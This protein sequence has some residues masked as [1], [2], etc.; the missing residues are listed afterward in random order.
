MG[1]L[2]LTYE[3]EF[4]FSLA[5]DQEKPLARGKKRL[6]TYKYKYNG[7]ELQEEL[8]LNVYDYGARFYDPA[9]PRFWQLD[10]MAETSRRFSPYSYAMDNPVFFID[11]DGMYAD[12]GDFINEKGKNIGNDGKSDGKLYAIKT[13][14]TKFDSGVKSSGITNSERKD[15]EKFITE[16]SGNTAA[17]E[18]NNIAYKNSV[19]YN[20]N[21]SAREGMIAE[22]GKDDGRGGTSDENNREHGGRIK[23]SDSSIVVSDPG[24]ICNP[25]T[26]GGVC[27]IPIETRGDQATFHDHPSGTL[28][29]ENKNNSSTYSSATVS[30]GGETSSYKQAPSPTDIADSSLK[31]RYEFARGE[32]KVYMYNS[33]GVLATMPQSSFV[34]A[35]KK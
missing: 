31:V 1:C 17:F 30:N 32:N 23:N 11:R 9:A 10:P 7:K 25:S 16:N 26:P 28:G 8:G 34:T 15:T 19:E 35:P 14:Q 21:K 18:A 33:T 5:Q 13:T 22:V 27:P 29:N 24:P 4:C 6:S 2:K 3:P 12:P 20:G